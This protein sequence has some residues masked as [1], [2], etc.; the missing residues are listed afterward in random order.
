MSDESMTLHPVNPMLQDSIWML[1]AARS[2]NSAWDLPLQI[3]AFKYKIL[4][5]LT[6]SD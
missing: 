1:E 3:L 5:Q 2:M 6:M 4:P